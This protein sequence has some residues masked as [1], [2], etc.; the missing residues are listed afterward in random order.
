MNSRA[1]VVR[2]IADNATF[3]QAQY[4]A[5]FVLT[6]YFSYLRRDPDGWLWFLA[7][8]AEQRRLPGN[9]RG[10]VCSFITSA[11][12]QTPLQLRSSV[13]PTPSAQGSNSSAVTGV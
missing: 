2:A 9:Y 7:E 12:Y 5:A 4:N 8:C 13:T 6:E 1:A 3:K 11:E 10:M